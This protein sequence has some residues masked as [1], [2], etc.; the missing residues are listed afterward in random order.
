[1][2]FNSIKIGRNDLCLCGSEKKYKRCCLQT[3][4]YKND[5][6]TIEQQTAALKGRKRLE[7]KLQHENLVLVSS[8]DKMLKISDAIIQIARE[9]LDRAKNKSQRKTAIETAC[10][11]WNISIM[12]KDEESLQNELNRLMSNISDDKQYQDDFTHIILSMVEKKK[13]LFPDET[14]LVA[15]FEIVDTKNYFSVN[16]ASALPT[17]MEE[18]ID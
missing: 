12:A 7:T 14:R 11:A 16:V 18:N 13:L 17:K 2:S 9:I 5:I 15:D 1:M 6:K 4:S 3:P 10:I 8:T